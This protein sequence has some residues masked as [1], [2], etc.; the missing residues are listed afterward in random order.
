MRFQI[1]TSRLLRGA[2]S[3]LLMSLCVNLGLCT[4]RS[5]NSIW[6]HTHPLSPAGW[7][8]FRLDGLCIRQHHRKHWQLWR[9]SCS[10]DWDR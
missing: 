9:W 5:S 3:S 1:E 8:L 7:E 4:K 2:T 10:G 6:G